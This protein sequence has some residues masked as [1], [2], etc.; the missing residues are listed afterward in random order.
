MNNKKMNN[1]FELLE[2]IENGVH[3]SPVLPSDVKNYLIDIDGTICDDIPNEEP[4]RMATAELYPDALETVNEW[5]D[6]GHII[7]FFTS[8]LEEHRTVTEKWLNDNGF[9]YHAMLMGKPR[10]GNYHWIDNHIVRATRFEGKFTNLV[11][12]QANI[13]VFEK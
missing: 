8:R 1:K 3:L 11:E 7:T 5:F 13:Q 4:E 10:G 6:Q 2:N 9:K 12:V